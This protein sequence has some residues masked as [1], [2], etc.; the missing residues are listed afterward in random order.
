MPRGFCIMLEG[1]GLLD[2]ETVPFYKRNRDEFLTPC[3]VSIGIIAR[4]ERPSTADVKQDVPEPSRYGSI[5]QKMLTWAVQD[6]K[7]QTNL[8]GLRAKVHEFVFCM[9]FLLRCVL[10]WSPPAWHLLLFGFRAPRIVNKNYELL[11]DSNLSFNHSNCYVQ[12]RKRTIH[13][14]VCNLHTHTTHTHTT[15]T[16][17]THA[18]TT[19][20]HTNV[21]V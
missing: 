14:C 13:L 2:F 8:L 7:R 3:Q 9:Q 10:P 4:Q 16:H 11:L 19:H 12:A 20:T 1:V 21:F 17:N 18:H 5:H 15:H 6:S